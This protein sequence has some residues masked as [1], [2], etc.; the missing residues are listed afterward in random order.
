MVLL[1]KTPE[2]ILQEELLRE[3]AE[4]LSRA[5]ERVSEVLQ[6]LHDLKE[7]IEGLL[8]NFSRN[9]SGNAVR[10]D[11]EA[12]DGMSMRILVEEINKKI[13]CYNDLREDA[14]LRYHYL[15]ITRE[16]L[17]MRRHHWVEEIY[18]IPARKGYLHDL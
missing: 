5:G 3:K 10:I 16:A 11:W 1:G 7:D 13:S 12:D 15:I 17:G 18:K 14:K 8:L 6:Q 4:V 9:E 2:N